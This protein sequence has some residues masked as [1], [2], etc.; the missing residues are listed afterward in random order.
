MQTLKRKS[1]RAILLTPEREILLIKIG[2]STATWTGWITPGGGL[3]QGESEMDGL[4]RELREELGFTLLPGA[5][6]VWTRFHCF[7]WNDRWVEQEEVFFLI[8]T[9]R[10][11]P[12]AEVDLTES[13]MLEFKEIRWWPI[14][15]IENSPECFAPT[16]IYHHLVNL[17]ENGPPTEPTDVGE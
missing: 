5:R 2:N 12:S 15:D 7:S 1:S 8:E 4:R 11:S 17:V 16:K 14:E 6:R 13:E 9:E 10:F 3:D